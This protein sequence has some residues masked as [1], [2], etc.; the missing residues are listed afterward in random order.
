[1]AVHKFALLADNE[2]FTIL[3]L[4]TEDPAAPQADR[5]VAGLQSDPVVIEITEYEQIINV[6]DV[7]NGTTFIPG[8][9]TVV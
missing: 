8:D 4:N 1:M 3:N 7:W 6:G 2:V 5:I 9:G